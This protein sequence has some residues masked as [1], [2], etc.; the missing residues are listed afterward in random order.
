VAD[1]LPL[2][3]RQA[4]DYWYW[5]ERPNKSKA[6]LVRAS[7]NG[8]E[9]LAEADDLAGYGVGG[10]AVAWSAREGDVWSVVRRR[11]GESAVLYS[12]KE[13]VGS[14]ALSDGRAAWAVVRGDRQKKLAPMPVLGP[15][16]EVYTSDGGKPRTVAQLVETQCDAVA[17]RGDTA[18]TVC[19]RN[20]G[21]AQTV[22]YAVSMKDGSVRRLV[23]E[24]GISQVVLLETGELVWT[25]LSRDSSSR[26]TIAA[27]CSLPPGRP[28]LTRA[29]WLP[30]IGQLTVA[31]HSPNYVGGTGVGALWI[32]GSSN[33]LITPLQP[34]LGFAVAAA[35]D[36]GILL[37]KFPA[38]G[39]Q[40]KLFTTPRL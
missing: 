6:K 36:R 13:V 11:A 7:A 19:H 38:E 32:I 4:G 35:G 31:G 27:I 23:G 14:P 5:I 1:S 28:P 16:V 24:E 40:F 18:Y 15:S 17:V 9:I 22:I 21:T 34:P 26:E 25:A 3:I 12:G 8:K 37:Y 2:E 39:T 29:D 20:Q 33:E 10:D 30:A